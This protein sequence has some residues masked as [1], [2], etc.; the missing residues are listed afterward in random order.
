MANNF[1]S[2][3]IVVDSAMASSYKSSVAATLGSLFTLRIQQVRWLDVGTVGDELR[4]IDPSSGIELIHE[5]LTVASQEIVVDFS[6]LGK[7][8]RDFQVVQR[9]SGRVEIHTI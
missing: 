7:I 4:I 2:N 6:A 8:W 5:R 1:T 9:D 3:P